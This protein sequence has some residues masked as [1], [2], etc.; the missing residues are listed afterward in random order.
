MSPCVTGSIVIGVATQRDRGRGPVRTSS[1]SG[2]GQTS[3]PSERGIDRKVTERTATTVTLR[4]DASDD[5]AGDT[6]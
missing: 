4:G 1:T 6:R 2:D 5:R 3:T